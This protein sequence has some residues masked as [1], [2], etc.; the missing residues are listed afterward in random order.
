M[1]PIHK[2][3]TWDAIVVG[4]GATGGAAARQLTGA[5]LR[6]L[7]L[8]AGAPVS[9]RS[10]YGSFL[11]NGCKQLYRHFVSHRQSVQKSHPTYWAT[12]PDFFVDDVDNPYTTPTWRRITPIWSASTESTV[13]GTDFHRYRTEIFEPR[14]R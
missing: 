8:E 14:A 12:N 13:S 1:T 7:V 6:I 11:S 10:D 9:D 2:P 3:E 4:S 5:G